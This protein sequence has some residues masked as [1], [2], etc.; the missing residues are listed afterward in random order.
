[1]GACTKSPPYCIVMEY[2]NGGSLK[3]LLMNFEVP[4]D[5]AYQLLKDIAN[6]LYHLH[7]EGK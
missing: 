5:M 6:G 2:V 3:H 4:L 7:V 1:M